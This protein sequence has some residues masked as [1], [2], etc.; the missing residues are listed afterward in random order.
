MLFENLISNFSD[1][2]TF[3]R[4]YSYFYKILFTVSIY[5]SINFY[6]ADG[7]TDKFLGTLSFAMKFNKTI[8]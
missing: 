7:G 2:F 1:S 6:P 8:P 3:F 4:R 5:E